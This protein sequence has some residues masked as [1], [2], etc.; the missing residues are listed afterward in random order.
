M[1][2]FKNELSFFSKKELDY[3]TIKTDG[4]R[5]L[6]LGGPFKAFFLEQS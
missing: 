1:L 3:L 4:D 2:E 5:F 6:S